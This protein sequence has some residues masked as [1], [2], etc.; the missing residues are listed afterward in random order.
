MQQLELGVVA[1]NAEELHQLQQRVTHSG[2][3]VTKAILLSTDTDSLKTIES[4]SPQAWM[5]EIDEQD[6]SL[7]LSDWIF[8][9]HEQDIPVVLV[10]APIKTSQAR[11]S[12][13]QR[14]DKKLLRLPG[15]VAQTQQRRQSGQSSLWPKAIWLLLAS[16]GGPEAVGEFLRNLPAGLNI[17]FVYVQHIDE[18]FAQTL[19]KAIARDSHYPVSMIE[20]G[21]LLK[22]EEVAIVSSERFTE[23]Q[24]NGSFIVQTLPWRGP[25][26]PSMDQ[27]LANFSLVSG[28]CNAIVFSGMGDDGARAS[29]LLKRAGGEL[30]C[31]SPET[32]ACPAMPEAVLALDN[33]DF[34]GSPRELA[35]RLAHMNR[36]HLIVDELHALNSGSQQV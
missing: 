9:Q 2:H 26:Q 12:W 29:R 35:E 15:I 13:C 33:V 11:Q 16:T 7:E 17:A 4:I 10:E 27:V 8:E 5:M 34:A 31:Q 3:R 36:G 14:L 28:H 32:C 21:G 1:Q 18:N 25:Y 23:L 19:S 22:A 20:H 6:I 24:D 30:W